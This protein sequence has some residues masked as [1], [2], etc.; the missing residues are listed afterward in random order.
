[1]YDFIQSALTAATE[2]IAIAGFTGI[3]AHAVFKQHAK[4]AAIYTEVPH[5]TAAPQIEPDTEVDTEVDTTLESPDIPPQKEAIADDIWETPVV[6]S[7]PR[8]WVRQ[9]RSIKPALMLMPAKEEIK[10]VTPPRKPATKE[11]QK[12]HLLDLNSLD[13]AALRKLCSKHGINWRNARG[14]GK[15][16]TKAAMIFQLELSCTA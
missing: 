2:I 6:T 16:L 5:A 9:P 4:S 14:Q 13:S 1:M 15:H 3:A 12:A 11:A 8:Y 7:A 10:A